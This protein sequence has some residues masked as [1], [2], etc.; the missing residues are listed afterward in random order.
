MLLEGES[1]GVVLHDYLRRLV[2][3]GRQVIEGQAGHRHVR[4][5]RWLGVKEEAARRDSRVPVLMEN[6][7]YKFS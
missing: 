7:F 2:Y 4:A 1:G 3:G 6:L 5:T